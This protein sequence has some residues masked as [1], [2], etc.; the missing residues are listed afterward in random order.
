MKNFTIVSDIFANLQKMAP[1]KDPTT[2]MMNTDAFR[3]CQEKIN[4]L[5]DRYYKPQTIIEKCELDPKKV[6]KL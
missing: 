3:R 2:G 6:E 4:F 5:A 1:K